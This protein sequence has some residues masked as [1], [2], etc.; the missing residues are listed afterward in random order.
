MKSWIAML[1]TLPSEWVAFAIVM[2]PKLRFVSTDS[3]HI[4]LRGQTDQDGP[5]TIA[6]SRRSTHTTDRQPVAR[7]PTTPRTAWHVLT[8]ILQFPIL[9]RTHCNFIK[10]TSN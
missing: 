4:A 8:A 10:L 3:G 5:P 2:A 7:L 6:G 1:S 9:I